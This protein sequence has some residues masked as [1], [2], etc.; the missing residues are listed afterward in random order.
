MFRTV[1][2]AAILLALVGG[3]GSARVAHAAN[4]PDP[5]GD[6]VAPTTPPQAAVPCTETVA[7]G[8]APV[9]ATTGLT[10]AHAA[11]YA[12]SGFPTLCAGGRATVTIAFLNT[13]SLGWYGNAALG[14]WGPEPGQ[15][16]ASALG[17]DGSG[18]SPATSWSSANRPGIQAMPYIGPGQVLWFQFNV[19]APTTPGLYKLGLRPLLEG[20][21]WLDD[22]NLTFSVLVKSDDDHVPT[23]PGG[24]VA[25]PEVPRTYVPA[26]LIDG[27]RTIRVPSLMYHYV[28][29][30]PT[31]DPNVALR[32]DLTVSPTDFE[33]MLKYLRD[34]GYHTITTKDLWWSLD[35]TA[36][37]PSKPVMLTFDDGYADAYSVAMPL[38]R[39]YGMTGTFFVTVNLVDR[40]GYLS[41]AEVKALA[42]AGM[43]VESHAMDHV[44]MMKPLNDQIYQMCRARDFL[45]LWTGTDVRHFAYPSGDY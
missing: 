16:R 10:G 7:P 27:S 42:D 4:V 35:Q 8:V 18:G 2:V 17:G 5:S 12:R 23:L 43:D 33:A 36:A 15:D 21:Q 34:N 19:Q 9:A 3:L 28:S 11:L 14:T 26:T 6:A 38:L 29:W 39:A 31:S 1:C 41:R 32:K 37:L 40:P 25:Q 45:S 22:P 13:G 20:Q 24:P 30:L 44:S